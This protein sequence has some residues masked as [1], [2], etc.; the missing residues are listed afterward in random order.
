MKGFVIIDQ[1]GA[2]LIYNKQTGH[3]G[4]KS[5]VRWTTKLDEASIIPLTEVSLILREVSGYPIPATE[6]RSVHLGGG[7]TMP[8]WMLEINAADPKWTEMEE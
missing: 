2:Y 8:Q 7:N 3:T 4:V 1:G 6:K 5:S